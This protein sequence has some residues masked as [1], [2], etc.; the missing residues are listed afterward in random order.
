MERADLFST[1][2]YMYSFDEKGIIF[3]FTMGSAA[4]AAGART[5]WLLLR[6]FPTLITPGTCGLFMRDRRGAH[7]FLQRVNVRQIIQRFVDGSFRDECRICQALVIEQATEGLQPDGSLANIL[8]AIQVRAALGRGVIAMPH[9]H[10]AQ[11]YGALQLIERFVK[12]VLAHDVVPG[13]VSVTG[14]D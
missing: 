7:Q 11:S 10:I 9:V 6:G 4:L 2:A 5:D 14:V 12:T 8:M 3:D 1:R 13:D